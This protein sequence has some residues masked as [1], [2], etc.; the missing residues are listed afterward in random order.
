[1]RQK[2]VA[3]INSPVASTRAN[4]STKEIMLEKRIISSN[5]QWYTEKTLS[6]TLERMAS[7]TTET[8]TR[9]IPYI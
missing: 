7:A 9:A 1:M 5:L 2:W 3:S 8:D 4:M 6:C